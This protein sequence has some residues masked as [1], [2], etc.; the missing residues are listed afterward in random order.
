MLHLIYICFLTGICLWQILQIQICLLVVVGPG[1][2]SKS[3][4]FT[5]SIASHPEGP[6]GRLAK[7]SNRAPIGAGGKGRHNLHM[8]CQTA[9]TAPARVGCVVWSQ[10]FIFIIPSFRCHIQ[11][12]S[13]FL[14]LFHIKCIQITH[15]SLLPL[16]HIHTYNHHTSM[17]SLHSISWANILPLPSV[18][19]LH[20]HF[21]LNNFHF[22]DFLLLVYTLSPFLCHS[23]I[24]INTF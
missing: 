24:L 13:M 18:L 23:R 10:Y 9:L 4:A 7:N 19:L 2:V 15:A 21:H 8:V 17:P 11:P 16:V 12:L 14:F 20:Q 1:L 6:H 5:R 22:L 3:P